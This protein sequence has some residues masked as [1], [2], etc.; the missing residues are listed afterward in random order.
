MSILDLR[1]KLLIWLTLEVHIAFL[2]NKYHI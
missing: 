1:K 2:S